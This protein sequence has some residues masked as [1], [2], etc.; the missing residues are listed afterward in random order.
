MPKIESENQF[1]TSIKGRNSVLICPAES[2]NGA[3]T[4]GRTDVQRAVLTGRTFWGSYWSVAISVSARVR[5]LRFWRNKVAADALTVCLC[6][7]RDAHKKKGQEQNSV[8]S[9]Q[10]QQVAICNA[11]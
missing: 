1:L 3:L 6:V 11:G 4:D 2:E 5:F 10:I 9:I 8:S 7:F